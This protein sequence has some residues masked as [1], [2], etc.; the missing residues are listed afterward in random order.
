[1]QRALDR[2]CYQ[3]CDTLKSQNNAAMNKCSMSRVVKED[4][5]G[6]KSSLIHAAERQFPNCD[7]RGRSTPW[8]PRCELCLVDFDRKLVLTT[9]PYPASWRYII[10][11]LRTLSPLFICL[12]GVFSPVASPESVTYGMCTRS[13]KSLKRLVVE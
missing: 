12:R 4:I 7:C 10:T 8:R 11:T 13:P 9:S 3:Q 2:P 5:D 6:C 1:M